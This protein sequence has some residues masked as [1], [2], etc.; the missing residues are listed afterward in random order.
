[1]YILYTR[2]I[3]QYQVMT[4]HCNCSMYCTYMYIV[5]TAV[6]IKGND[7][8]LNIHMSYAHTHPLQCT[9]SRI[10]IKSNLPI[11]VSITW[12]WRLCQFIPSDVWNCELWKHMLKR[13]KNSRG[14]W[15]N[16]NRSNETRSRR[17]RSGAR[18]QSKQIKHHYQLTWIS[19][20]CP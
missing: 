11:F 18:V 19:C 20:N 13:F 8:M 2:T 15:L 3:S 9:S 7:S 12:K 1:M 14:L 16:H 17:Y 4:L 5:H 10:I 6:S